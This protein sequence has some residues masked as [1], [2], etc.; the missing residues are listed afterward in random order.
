MRV[1]G[2]GSVP[3]PD[4]GR[5]ERLQEEGLLSIAF[6]PDYA[7]AGEFYVYLTARRARV[8]H[9]GEVEIREYHRSAA[10]SN[11]ADPAN[12]RVL[13]ADPARRRAQP[14]RRPAAVRARRAALRRHGRRRR[15]RTTSSATRR[16]RRRCWA[17]CCGSIRRAAGP[18]IA[19]MGL[20][21]PWRFSFDA[22]R[23][24]R[25]RRRR[26]GP[27]RGGR[28]RARGQLRLAV[29]RGPARV[30]DD[31]DGLRGP[32]TCPCSR[33]R[34]PAGFC[35]I[36]GGYVVRDPGLPT[37]DG[38]YVYGDNCNRRSTRSIWRTRAATGRRR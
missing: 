5:R 21:N 14:Q 33:H 23:P 12:Y 7:S 4:R 17:S 27:V 11:I 20:R 18:E 34:T 29:L 32:G 22:G 26:P 3:R 8:G 24:D 9:G 15:L 37:L 25:D 1:A 31:S 19:A 30:Q 2:G 16:T 28:R 10:N 38:R 6:P 35:A 13:L 36:V